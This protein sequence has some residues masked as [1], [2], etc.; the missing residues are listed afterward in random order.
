MQKK[1]H[2]KKI[3]DFIKNS[4]FEYLSKEIIDK[5]KICILDTICAAAMGSCSDSNKIA[6]KVF[7]YNRFNHFCDDKFKKYSS[8]WFSNK[9]TTLPNAIFINAN[10][11][12]AFDIDDGLDL[13]RGH[14]GSLI[15]PAILTVCESNN[16]NTK[17]IITSIVIGYDLMFYISDYLLPYGK[18]GYSI[19]HGSGSIGA[20][21]TA[22]SLS[23]LFNVG[24]KVMS[25]SLRVSQSFMPGGNNDLS[26]LQGPM[27]KENIGWGAF[28]GYNSFLLA[29]N[30]YTG[31]ASV[32]ENM[33]SPYNAEKYLYDHSAI[34]DTYIKSFAACRFAHWPLDAFKRLRNKYIFRNEE[35]KKIEIKTFKSAVKLAVKN[36]EN[37][38]GI[39]YS[40][41]YL[42]AL[43]I[44]YNDVN[45]PQMDKRYKNDKEIKEIAKKV[46]L[47]Q[48]KRFEKEYD[49]GEGCELIIVLKNGNII[50][51]TSK[52]LEGDKNNQFTLNDIYKK[53]VKN[54]QSFIDKKKILEI[55]ETVNDFEKIEVVALINLL[56]NLSNS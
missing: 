23:N 43:L 42:L 28:T 7:S 41:Q 16:I 9:K 8:V 1:A 18:F 48:D 39:Q 19:D 26:V 14:A 40:I 53:F 10:S 32:I 27:T 33:I 17:K 45:L 46:I 34:Q 22:A 20:I 4:K 54:C 6:L 56:T 30:G 44:K 5:T 12:C 55:T 21:A 31:Q 47:K 11:S 2:F 38:E 50:K 49:E 52:K 3:L 25:E 29:R 51:E 13:N 35:I 15:I 24:R 37:I 36:P